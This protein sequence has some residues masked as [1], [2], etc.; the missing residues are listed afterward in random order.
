MRKGDIFV[1]LCVMLVSFK[2]A[3]P[4]CKD[5]NANMQKLHV[6][7]EPSDHVENCSRELLFKGWRLSVQQDEESSGSGRGDVCMGHTNVFHTT[8]WYTSKWLRR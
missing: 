3:K 4:L 5:A 7:E 6:G 1:S 8:E 2:D